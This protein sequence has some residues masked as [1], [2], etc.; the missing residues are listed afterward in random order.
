MQKRAPH[1][2]T[3]QVKVRLLPD[4]VTD[5]DVF[6]AVVGVSRSLAVEQLIG[7]GL[8]RFE[9]AAHNEQETA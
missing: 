3:I 7:A 2:P 8:E 6:A 1:V 4:V 9:R 5:L